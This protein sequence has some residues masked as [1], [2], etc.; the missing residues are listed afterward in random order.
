MKN[1]IKLTQTLIGEIIEKSDKLLEG[2]FTNS[3]V[4]LSL[5]A[6][7]AIHEQNC[8]SSD[9]EIYNFIDKKCKDV[10][11]PEYLELQSMLMFNNSKYPMIKAFLILDFVK[12][13]YEKLKYYKNI[14]G[15]NNAQ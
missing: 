4:N 2:C 15:I 13:E 6:F 7:M 12:R 5:G 1:N 9:I 3:S 10:K 8:L 11:Q 14:G